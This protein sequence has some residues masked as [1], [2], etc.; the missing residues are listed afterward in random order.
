MFSAINIIVTDSYFWIIYLWAVQAVVLQDN[1]TVYLQNGNEAPANVNVLEGTAAN[2]SCHS[3]LAQIQY[4]WAKYGDP[5]FTVAGAFLVFT[6][7]Q[8]QFNGRYTCTARNLGTAESA[9]ISVDLT[10]IYPPSRPVISGPDI[11]V[12]G[13]SFTLSCYADGIPLPNY[14]WKVATHVDEIDTRGPQYRYTPSSSKNSI[15]R[16]C[17]AEVTL[18]PT[19]GTQ[20]YCSSY[21]EKEIIVHEKTSILSLRSNVETVVGATVDIECKVAG[22]PVPRIW[23]TKAGNTEF[24]Y[25]TGRLS[26]QNVQVYHAGMYSCNAENTMTPSSQESR[27]TNDSRVFALHVKDS[28]FPDDCKEFC[29]PDPICNITMTPLSST[30]S[31][32]PIG[33]PSGL[34]GLIVA[35]VI[36]WL[37]AA[38]LFVL[39]IVLFK[40]QRQS[41]TISKPTEHE[42]A[43]AHLQNDIQTE[44]NPRRERTL[45]YNRIEPE[46]VEDSLYTEIQPEVE[47][48]AGPSS[49]QNQPYYLTPH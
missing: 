13:E 4:S 45:P 27:T 1:L 3:P 2:F 16:V 48:G 35:T 33:R 38:T 32:S 8:R 24:T 37:L 12:L 11:V 39:S 10:V 30:V 6:R 49:D 28:V 15:H 17:Y 21:E 20:Q 29:N 31:S 22:A 42:L 23:W 46:D 40:R 26:L 18:F 14:Y 36:G 5:L 7:I 9:T 41:S 25:Q 47:H 44:A 19:V 43:K 34:T